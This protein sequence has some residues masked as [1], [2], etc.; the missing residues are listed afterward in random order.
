MK[1]T[2][3]LQQ[4][5]ALLR[6]TRLANVAFAYQGLRTFVARAGRARLYGEVT[7]RAGDPSTGQPWPT[8][9]A[10]EGSQAVLEE[11]FLDEDIVELADILAFLNDSKSAGELR[12]QLE[13]L[14]ILVIPR[15]HRELAAAGVLPNGRATPVEDSN[16]DPG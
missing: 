15:L 2:Q 1:F 10:E 3:L 7:L 13:D 14:D 4:R 16:L 9:T 8:L 12:F 11:H 5:D 6:Q